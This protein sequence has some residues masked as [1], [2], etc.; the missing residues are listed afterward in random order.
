MK[1]SF[2]KV[3]AKSS[4][5]FHFSNQQN[6][7]VFQ[8]VGSRKHIHVEE[9]KMAFEVS[10]KMDLKSTIQYFNMLGIDYIRACKYYDSVMQLESN[11]RLKLCE[12]HVEPPRV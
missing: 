4:D 10:N 3:N 6:R 5:P 12:P 11:Y 8:K 2:L 1:R 9:V 7:P